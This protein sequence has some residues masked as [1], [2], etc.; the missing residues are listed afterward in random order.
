[1]RQQILKNERLVAK[2]QIQVELH[3]TFCCS[4]MN[5]IPEWKVNVCFNIVKNYCNESKL[6]R[7]CVKI[8][9]SAGWKEISVLL[10][11]VYYFIITNNKIIIITTSTLRYWTTFDLVS[12][13]IQIGF[14]L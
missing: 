7:Q 12:A 3:A 14:T 6:Q 8:T 10:G 5:A 1:M 2:S 4:K 9:R 11:L 13:F